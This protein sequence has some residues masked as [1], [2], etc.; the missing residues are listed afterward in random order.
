MIFGG[1]LKKSLLLVA[2]VDHTWWVLLRY[3]TYLVGVSMCF[4]GVKWRLP[5]AFF[6]CQH[7]ILWCQQVCFRVSA[8]DL[9]CQLAFFK[10]QHVILWCQQVCFTQQQHSKTPAD[11]LK[12]TAYTRKHPADTIKSHVDT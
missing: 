12:S 10:C 1:V 2:L 9:G 3:V 5:L 4:Y 7:V 11:T 8:C 6:K